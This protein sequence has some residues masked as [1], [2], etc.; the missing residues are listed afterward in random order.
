M[1]VLI[2]GAG[3]GFKT[4][5]TVCQKLQWDILA[6]VDSNKELCG[7]K[8]NNIKIILPE[9]IQD[10]NDFDA[11]VIGTANKD[12]QMLA[13]EY[14]K[15]VINWN[16]IRQ[17]TYG[18][19]E[20]RDDI[21]VGNLSPQN[22]KNCRVV[23][24][25]IQMLEEIAAMYDDLEVFAEIGVAFGDY[26][27]EIL[28]VINPKKL[29]LIDAWEGDRYGNG[30]DEVEKKFKTQIEMKQVELLKGYSDIVL[31]EL[32]DHSIDV[33]YIDTDHSYEVT[34]K[35]LLLCSKKVKEGG[36][37]CGHDYV[38]VSPIS[39]YRYGVVEAVNKFCVEYKYEM[40][41]MTMETEGYHSFALRKIK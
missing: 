38:N 37:I 10:E 1:K 13:S 40:I 11:I 36:L 34:W 8:K 30:R 28:R 41:F 33:A 16:Q 25:R 21:P 12:V 35:E 19:E 26:S 18:T 20:P 22:V 39:R 4:A 27:S 2:W 5:Y 6:I 7:T 24:D 9:G 32:D 17:I 31:K 15:I 23:S 29:L 14:S 3:K